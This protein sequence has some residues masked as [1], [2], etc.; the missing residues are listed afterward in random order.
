[1]KTFP[2]TMRCLVGAMLLAGGLAMA[3][4]QQ[5]GTTPAKG[6]AS[7]P[8]AGGSAAA[9]QPVAG[10]SGDLIATSEQYSQMVLQAKQPVVVDFF[11]SCPACRALAPV[12]AKMENEFQGRVLFYRVDANAAAQLAS[13]HDVEAMPTLLFYR[14]G[15]E[16]NRVVGVHKE[17]ELRRL[18]NALLK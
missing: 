2:I 6:M 11:T 14:N 17:G 15:K 1:M 8:S 7:T 9:A 12:M 5:N 10:A 3:G 16:V 18:I 4:C 13:D